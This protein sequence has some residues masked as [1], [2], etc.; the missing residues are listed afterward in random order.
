MAN[1][2]Q[3]YYVGSFNSAIISGTSNLAAGNT[4]LSA[5]PID[6]IPGA[7]S[8]SAGVWAD[9]ELSLPGGLS[10]TIA[11]LLTVELY[12]VPSIDGSN[13]L[14]F[15]SNFTDATAPASLYR[16]AFQVA[17]YGTASTAQLL[18]LTD[19]LLPPYNV[20]VGLRNMTGVSLVGSGGSP[21]TVGYTL[22]SFSYG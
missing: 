1:T 13:Y 11:S 4:I 18:G 7:G 2:N 22:K 8:P 9:F 14:T 15:F 3:G 12:L 21:Y 20:K 17:A 10:A 6:N 19:V 5:S 16:G